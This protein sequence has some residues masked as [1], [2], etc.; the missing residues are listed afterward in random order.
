VSW[1]SAS[2]E[3]ARCGG[4]ERW[5]GARGV[6]RD[7]GVEPL[8]A[9]NEPACASRCRR[10]A[11]HAGG[12]ASG[13]RRGRAGVSTAPG[14][15]E[16]CAAFALQWSAMRRSCAAA[17]H[18]YGPAGWWGREGAT[19]RS[20]TPAATMVRPGAG[21]ARRAAAG[22]FRRTMRVGLHQRGS[23]A[24]EGK[25]R[26]DGASSRPHGIGDV[27]PAV[28]AARVCGGCPVYMWL[29]LRPT[30][31]PARRATCGK[32][33]VAAPSLRQQ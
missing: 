1:H 2:G 16:G 18:T 19:G 21:A 28:T 17:R 32:R 22:V 6:R 31:L 26:P 15:A 4:D 29:R 24:D 10:S 25:G 13:S 23:G 5:W 7:A 8:L 30:S 9:G 12:L 20:A 27:G 11:P 33:P 14:P 3:F